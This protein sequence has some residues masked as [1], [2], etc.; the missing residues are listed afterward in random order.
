MTTNADQKRKALPTKTMKTAA[1]HRASAKAN[2]GGRGSQSA[3]DN[4]LGTLAGL[5]IL[6]KTSPS[7][8]EVAR[9]AKYGNAKSPGFKK[10]VSRL[11]TKGYIDYPC[12]STMCLTPEGKSVAPVPLTPPKLLTPKMVQLLDLLADG[13]IHNRNEVAKALEYEDKEVR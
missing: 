7:R 13:A 11:S 4:I 12:K 2:R 10:D 1:K 6:G 5:E 9:R 3:Q 8:A